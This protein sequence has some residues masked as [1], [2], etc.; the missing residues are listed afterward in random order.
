MKTMKSVSLWAFDL[1]DP[2]CEATSIRELNL[3][4][5]HKE[6]AGA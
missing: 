6:S 1:P 5:T 3:G 4:F 2:A